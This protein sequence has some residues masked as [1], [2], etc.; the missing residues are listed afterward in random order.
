[1]SHGTTQFEATGNGAAAEYLLTAGGVE[2]LRAELLALRAQKEH[3]IS[4]RL[5]EA[6]AFGDASGNDDYLAIKEEEAVL[7]ARI[8]SLDDVLHRASVVDQSDL[9]ADAVAIGSTVTVEDI[10]GG[11]TDR[12]RVVGMHEQIRVGEVSAG[13]PVGRALLGRRSGENARVVLPSGQIRELRVVATKLPPADP[14]A[15]A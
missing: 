5:R 10:Q 4:A 12:Y 11:S 6:R 15:Q 2:T 8:T 7:D 9:E 1:M 14:K 3:E 13:S